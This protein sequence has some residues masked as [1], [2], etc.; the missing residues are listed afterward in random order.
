MNNIIW[1]KSSRVKSCKVKSQATKAI[2]VLQNQDESYK[3]KTRA[4]KPRRE[5]QNQDESCKA[6][7]RATESQSQKD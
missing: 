4:T 2:R 5:L 1:G 7:T 3:A 6:K